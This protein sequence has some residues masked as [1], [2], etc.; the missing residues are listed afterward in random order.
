[1]SFLEGLLGMSSRA[2]RPLMQDLIN[3]QQTLNPLKHFFLHP[4][5]G[6]FMALLKQMDEA[7]KRE[8]K[9][10]LSVPQLTAQMIVNTGKREIGQAEQLITQM[11]VAVREME[12]DAS[13]RLAAALPQEYK[14]LEEI[15]AYLELIL[16]AFHNDYLTLL[17][18]DRPHRSQYENAYLL[19]HNLRTI[20]ARSEKDLITAVPN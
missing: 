3:L 9:G 12:Q 13:H 19:A 8:V 5:Q 4:G 16:G 1:M 10:L 11:K 2:H 18:D 6:V 17:N 15:F 7:Q 14:Q 20:A